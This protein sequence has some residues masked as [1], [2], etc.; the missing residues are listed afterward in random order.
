MNLQDRPNAAAGVPL[1]SASKVPGDRKP[2]LRRCLEH[3]LIPPGELLRR[4]PTAKRIVHM[5][6]SARLV[7]QHLATLEGTDKTGKL[8]QE[9][10]SI[11]GGSIFL[12]GRHVMDVLQIQALDDLVSPIP[13]VLVQIEDANALGVA[14]GLEMTHGDDQ[15]VESAEARG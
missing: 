14:V 7:Q 13:I 9:R 15:A 10:L 5:R 11:S 8:A 4:H 3:D 2:D 12:A 1:V 6:I